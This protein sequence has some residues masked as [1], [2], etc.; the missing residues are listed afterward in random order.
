MNGFY[1]LDMCEIGLKKVDQDLH[2]TGKT[3]YYSEK[4]ERTGLLDKT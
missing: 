2:L 4:H 1:R 3:H